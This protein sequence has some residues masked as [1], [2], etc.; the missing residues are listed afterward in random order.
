MRLRTRA[1]YYDSYTGSRH[2]NGIS[3]FSIVE[4]AF[5]VQRYRY[6]SSSLVSAG[7]G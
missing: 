5:R 4:S 1:N 7:S 6:Y 3:V 2:A